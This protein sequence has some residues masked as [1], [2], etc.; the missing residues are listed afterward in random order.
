VLSVQCPPD[1]GHGREEVALNDWPLYDPQ[2]MLAIAVCLVA[3]TF[4][5]LIALLKTRVR[6]AEFAR[7]QRAVEE[8]SEHVKELQAAEQL[9]FLKEINA[10]K[11]DDDVPSIIPSFLKTA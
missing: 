2:L 4:V 11:K 8:M 9:R 6:R 5:L 1:E 10:P 7:L 3:I